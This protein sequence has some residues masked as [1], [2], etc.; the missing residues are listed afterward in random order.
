MKYLKSLALVVLLSLLAVKPLAAHPHAWIVMNATVQFNDKGLV[1]GLYFEWRFDREYSISAV[2]GLDT[3]KDGYFSSQE[4]DPLTAENIKALKE[5]DYFV[6]ARVDGKKTGYGPITEYSQ[7]LTN[8]LLT[9]SFTIPFAKPVDPRKSKFY[10]KAY[11][12]TFFIA[13]DFQEKA[14][15][16]TSGPMPSQCKIKLKKIAADEQTKKTKKM[17]AEKPKNWQP[18][19]D[20]DFGALFAQPVVIECAKKTAAK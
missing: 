14:P 3:N 5:Y 12:P 13:M 15:V 18:A 19:D 1:E 6:Y 11:D 9:M 20:E 8:D 16:T 7:Y 2:E 17:L 10:F 4:L